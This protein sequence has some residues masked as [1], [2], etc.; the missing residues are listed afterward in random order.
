MKLYAVSLSAFR[1]K[2]LDGHGATYDQ[3]AVYI[4]ARGP[5]DAKR[6]ILAAAKRAG[7]W[8]PET[9]EP[10]SVAVREIPGVV[11]QVAGAI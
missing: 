11:C 2:P 10:T 6:R 9:H 4:A 7:L 8:P 1:H 5:K 3:R